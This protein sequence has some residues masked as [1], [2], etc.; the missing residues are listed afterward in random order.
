MKEILLSNFIHQ[1][2]TALVGRENGKS[3]RLAFTEKG[4]DL[5]ALEK[6]DDQI[7]II[8]P[9]D[10][11]SVNKSYFLGA[12][13][14]RVRELGKVLFNEKYQFKTSEHIQNKIDEAI[15]NALLQASPEQILNVC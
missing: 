11:V 9:E 7:V 5:L 13:A 2:E 15:D 1:D 14:D 8:I 6:A 10:V 12:F 4:I 3:L